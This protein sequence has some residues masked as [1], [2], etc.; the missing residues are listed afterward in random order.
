MPGA[1]SSVVIIGGSGE[2]ACGRDQPLRRGQVRFVVVKYGLVAIGSPLQ[3]LSNF[4]SA[5]AD[6]L[7]VTVC[8]ESHAETLAGVTF[9]GVAMTSAIYKIHAAGTS[10]GCCLLPRPPHRH[11]QYRRLLAGLGQRGSAQAPSLS[12]FADMLREWHSPPLMITDGR[13]TLTNMLN[14][15]FVVAA[16][17]GDGTAAYAN[18]PLTQIVGGGDTG[19]CDG[20]SRL[21]RAQFGRARARLRSRAAMFAR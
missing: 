15:A 16:S 6:K 1:T 4:N 14:D 21:F 10:A 17:V 3:T 11:G 12:L 5:G 13:C 2:P 8:G 18:P 19:G 9:G 20:A 7:V